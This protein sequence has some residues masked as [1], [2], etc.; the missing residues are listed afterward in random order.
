[1]S[2]MNFDKKAY[3][4]AMLGIVLYIIFISIAIL[5]YAGGT[6]DN[7]TALGYTFFENTF[8]DTGRLVAHN[9]KVNIIAMIL[10]AIAYSSISVLFFPFYYVF[11]KIFEKS[12]ISYKT[13]IVGSL[14]GIL[15]S[16][17][18]ITV[19]FFPADLARPIHML[20][21]VGAYV[22][23]FFMAVSYTVSLY[24]GE[25]LSRFYTFIF[26]GF[27]LFFFAMLMMKLV[28]I[29]TDFRLLL[30]TGQKL[31]RIANL[32]SF[33]ILLYGLWNLEGI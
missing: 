21:A 7:P 3:L 10:F 11:P 18:F 25:K 30:C 13:A 15:S 2:A 5:T 28:G 8:S 1:M 17:T 6:M 26:M 32:I 9:G 27:S 33:F 24:L 29:I 4:L 16:C 14:L 23:I 20:L 31:G 12:T 22:L 19:L